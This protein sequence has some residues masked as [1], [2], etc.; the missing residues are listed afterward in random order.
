MSVEL[1]FA[2]IVRAIFYVVLVFAFALPFAFLPNVVH[3]QLRRS[4]LL[5]RDGKR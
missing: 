3:F 1:A 4:D 5:Q 2:Y